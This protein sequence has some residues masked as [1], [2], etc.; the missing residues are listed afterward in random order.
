MDQAVEAVE[1]QPS[2][3]ARFI[4]K[5]RASAAIV[6]TV[7]DVEEAIAY[8]VDLCGKK[9]PCRSMLPGA[10]DA[11]GP[12]K[13]LPKKIIA[14]PEL[15][16]GAYRLLREQCAA[17]GFDCIDAKMRSFLSG[18]DIGFSHA[19]LGIVETGTVVLDCPG[20]ELRLATMI[21][22]THVCVLPESNI[23][24]DGFAA[25]SQILRF[26]HKTPNYTAFITGPSRTA[27]IERVLAIGVHGPL[28]LHILIIEDRS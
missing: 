10:P 17:N 12:G 24:E 28:E 20:E 26:M 14:A 11:D 1:K 8:T 23:V 21:C 9:R 18:I 4:E 13:N 22:E 6:T 27:D 7:A 2:D 15:A 5:A 25:K 16:P 19:D 3:R